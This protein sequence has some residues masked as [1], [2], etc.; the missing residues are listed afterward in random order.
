M[1]ECCDSSNRIKF[2]GII[3]LIYSTK[4]SKYNFNNCKVELYNEYF[5]NEVKAKYCPICGRKLGSDNK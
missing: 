1:C 5:Q 4:I 3:K 2:T